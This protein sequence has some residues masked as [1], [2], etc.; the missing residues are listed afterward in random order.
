MIL[1][2]VDSHCHL[3]FQEFKEDIEHVIALAQQR[4]VNTLLSICTKTEEINDIISIAELYTHVFASVGIHPHESEESLKSFNISQLN[5]WL[6]EQAMHPKVIGIGETGLDFYYEHSLRVQQLLAFQ[7]HIETALE[8][9]LP[10]IVH[11]RE[12]ERETISMLK[13]YPTA[14]GVI[15]CFSGTQYL[16]EEALSLG[17][18]ISI[19][20]IATFKK[21]EE[22]RNIIKM[23]PVERI[24][25]ET[26]A[27]FLAP[28]PYRGQRNE[29]ALM[30]HTAQ[31][32]ADLKEIP[33]EELATVTTSNFFTLFSKAHQASKSLHV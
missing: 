13:D 31:L 12:A 28:I 22:L 9:N 15:H 30:I 6:R 3:N 33:L 24:L 10:L 18:Y 7:T 1:N 27:P 25:L 14:R 2:F 11:T 16:A 21:A 4:G 8:V 20:G 32:V 23:L 19:S 26:D 17:Y 29:P 5:A